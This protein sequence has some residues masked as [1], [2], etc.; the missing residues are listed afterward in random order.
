VCASYQRIWFDAPLSLIL[1]IYGS[2]FQHH[3]SGKTLF[4]LTRGVGA[5][6]E[7]TPPEAFLDMEIPMPRCPHG[8]SKIAANKTPPERN[9][10]ELDALMPSILSKAFR[11]EL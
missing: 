4:T 8:S 5:R 2:W 1:G 7:R 6:R 9:M 11:D 10:A 3:G